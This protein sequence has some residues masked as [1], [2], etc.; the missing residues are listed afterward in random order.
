M[1]VE[2]VGAVDRLAA[3]LGVEV[4]PARGEAATAQDLQHA[5]RHLLDRHRE[6]IDVPAEPIV[7]GVGVDRAEDP[8]VD[9]RGDLVGEVVAGE[10]GVVD[11]DVDLDLVGEVVLL[12]ERMHRGDVVVVLVLGRLE[13]LWLEQDRAAE[14]D[15]LLVLDDHRQEPRQLVELALACRC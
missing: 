11:L 7:A 9:G 5:E 1:G 6:A 14:P 12:Q 2:Q 8:G 4:Q 15:A 13:R 10:R 3:Q